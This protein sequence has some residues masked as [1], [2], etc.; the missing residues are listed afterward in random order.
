MTATLLEAGEDVTGFLNLRSEPNKLTL[1]VNDN[2]RPVEIVAYK[3][4]FDTWH[5]PCLPVN[6]PR[7]TKI[8]KWTPFPEGATREQVVSHMMMMAARHTYMNVR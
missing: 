5:V 6:G 8:R 4:G 2:L 1:T 7:G 3:T